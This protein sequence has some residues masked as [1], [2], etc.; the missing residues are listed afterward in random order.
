MVSLHPATMLSKK[1]KMMSVTI[2]FLCIK[3]VL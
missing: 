1:V 2:P 3:I